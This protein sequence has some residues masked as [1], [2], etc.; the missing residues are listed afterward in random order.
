M[1]PKAKTGNRT[2]A[3][4]AP[5]FLE[6]NFNQSVVME[7]Y[8]AARSTGN[9]FQR[10][11]SD[12]GLTEN[13]WRVMRMLWDCRSAT[14]SGIAEKTLCTKPNITSIL[15]KLEQRGV[16]ERKKD[17]FWDGRLV[18]VCASEDGQDLYGEVQ[19]R[20]QEIYAE[21]IFSKLSESEWETLLALLKKLQS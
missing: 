14:P 1:D 19:E 6:C 12:L 11:M 15:C 7:L 21:E 10:L 4:S 13:Q 17:H 18:D 16:V 3:Q 8:R 2:C 9:H 5:E 20:I